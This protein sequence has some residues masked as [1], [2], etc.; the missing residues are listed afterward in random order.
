MKFLI[1]AG[2]KGTRLWP[3]SRSDRPK[4]FQKLISEK[5]MLQETVDRLR[6]RFSL[7]DVYISTNENYVEEVKKEIPDFPVDNIICEP[8]FRERAAAIALV[9]T[10]LQGFGNESLAIL[11]SDHFLKEG[12]RLL[13]ILE[14]SDDF[15]KKNPEYMVNIG[16][17]AT[18]AETG[19]GYIKISENKLASGEFD[20]CGVAGFAEKPTFE[21]AQKYCQDG[22]YFWNSGISVCGISSLIDRYRRFI[23]GVFSHMQKMTE[24][25]KNGD[26]DNQLEKEYALMDIVSFEHEIS[27]KDDKIA[28]V[29]ADLGWSDVGSWSVL[30]DCLANQEE[31]LFRGDYI[32]IGSEGVLAYGKDRL[33]ATIG[34]KDVIIIDTGDVLLVCDKKKSQEV[35]KVVDRLINDGREDLL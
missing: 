25:I 1:M 32:D 11:P 3:M 6:P 30:K 31:N 15:I 29:V 24:I 2:G 13:D 19:Y 4:Q 9:L 16:I 35:K 22:S 5:T 26:I 12:G 33:L 17:K 34:L 18:G 27:E 14:D 28:V 20:F 21:I 23:P 8:L 7:E 10:R